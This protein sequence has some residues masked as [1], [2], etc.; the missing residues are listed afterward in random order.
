LTLTD[1]TDERR[2]GPGW[3][4]VPTVEFILIKT[5]IR[6]AGRLPFGPAT[7]VRARRRVLGLLAAGLLAGLLAA[8]LLASAGASD[9]S[10]APPRQGAAEPADSGPLPTL[11][12][13]VGKTFLQAVVDRDL[14]TSLPLC[15]DRVDFDGQVVTGN[16][17]VREELEQMF[18]RLGSRRRLRRVWVMS[19]AEARRRFGPPPSRLTLPDKGPVLVAFGRFHRG[20]LIAF[21]A[22]HRDRFR[23]VA[24]TD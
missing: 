24:L 15:A 21:V 2:S 6:P 13:L 18:G 14:K 1:S 22:P 7:A 11:G 12:V 16:R 23:V 10:P 17:K 8:G 20:G 5:L 4:G 3:N 9:A 19:L